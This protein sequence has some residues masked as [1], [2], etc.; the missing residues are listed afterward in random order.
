MAYPNDGE[1]KRLRILKDIRERMRAISA[2]NGY[3]TDVRGAEIFDSQRILLNGPFPFVSVIPLEGEPSSGG[4]STCSVSRDLVLDIVGAHQVTP[5]GGQWV[6]DAHWLLSD[7]VRAVFLDP[8]FK[9]PDGALLASRTEETKSEVYD[10]GEA[11]LALAHL[12]LR[13]SYRHK[14][15]DPTN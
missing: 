7:I 4:G 10:K 3:R 15:D 1:P 14:S 11:N 2:A 12:Q 5:Q 9:Q 13:V 6:D 8:Q